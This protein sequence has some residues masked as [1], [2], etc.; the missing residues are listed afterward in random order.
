MIPKS[1]LV[2]PDPI[3]SEYDG[4]NTDVRL[5]GPERTRQVN[6]PEKAQK[7]PFFFFFLLRTGDCVASFSRGEEKTYNFIHVRGIPHIF[8]FGFER[9]KEK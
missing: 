7:Y 3:K 8:S 1:H 9:M 4:G 6:V 2:L 5:Y